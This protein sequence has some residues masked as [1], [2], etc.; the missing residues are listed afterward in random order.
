MMKVRASKYLVKL[1]HIN[2]L[3]EW[4]EKVNLKEKQDVIHKTK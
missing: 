1:S 3:K 4:D 2:K